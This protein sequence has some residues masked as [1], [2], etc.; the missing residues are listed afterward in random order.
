VLAPTV[1]LARHIFKAPTAHYKAGVVFLAYLNGHQDH[2][3]LVDGLESARSIV[4]LAELFELA[5]EA[6]LL[7]DGERSS[8][9]MREALALAGIRS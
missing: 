5:D 9:R 2:F 3:K 4:H 1:P 8:A 6:G 7:F